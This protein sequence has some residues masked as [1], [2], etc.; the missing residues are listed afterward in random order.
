MVGKVRRSGEV[1]RLVIGHCLALQVQPGEVS[2]CVL[3]DGNV[4]CLLLTLV[5]IPMGVGGL[6][7]AQSGF[8]IAA[9]VHQI[10]QTL[11]RDAA[12]HGGRWWTPAMPAPPGV[13]LLL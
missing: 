10:R 13:L 3:L 9:G 7:W 8:L 2:L 12:R 6:R 5:D 11:E 1:I 4:L